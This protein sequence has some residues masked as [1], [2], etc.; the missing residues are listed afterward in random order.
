MILPWLEPEKIALDRAVAENRLGH[1]PMLLGSPGVG[2]RALADWLVQ[3][4]LCLD[5]R[6]GEA[7]GNCRSC[8]LIEG[9]THPDR[10]ELGLLEDKSEILVDQ[11]REFIASLSLTPSVGET[12]VGLISPAD[13]LNRNAANAL[14]K[15][16]EEP[17]GN[18]WLVLVVDAER[19]LP[20]TVLSRCQR[21]YVAVPDRAAALEWL[22]DRHG[23]RSPEQC[24][25]ALSLADGAPLLADAWL[26]EAGLE[27]GLAVR[28]AL[29]GVMRG[30]A[31]ESALIAEWQ[32]APEVIWP[33]LARWTERWLKS[34][35]AGP[36]DALAGAPLPGA[37]RDALDRLQA[38]WERALDGARLA[39]GPI[40]HDWMLRA[41]LADWR[42]IG[43]V[44]VR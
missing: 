28:D 5:P 23:D 40:R 14:L 18:V 20:P 16:L 37:E 25:M 41:W 7:C 26:G 17:S 43:G 11:V 10:F 29:A 24:A 1:A 19:R 22:A 38:C 35:L 21:R 39:G 32:Q 3:R 13:R 15:T 31:D 34:V 8:E 33:W 12:R 44:S 42:R 36:D 6:D 30:K 9:A 4:L 2:K 27:Q